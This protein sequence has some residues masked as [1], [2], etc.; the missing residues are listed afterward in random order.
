MT[1]IF[2]FGDIEL[3]DAWDDTPTI[4]PLQVARRLHT[5]RHQVD[6]LAGVVRTPPWHEIGDVE[7][8]RLTDFAVV[9][10]D[11]IS[12]REPD[13]PALLA[14]RIHEERSAEAWDDLAPDEQQIAIDLCDLLVEWLEREGPR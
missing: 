3:A 5:L 4:D 6:L 11:Y 9:I 2:E 8:G 14:R 10:V 1:D 13:N 7:R 12:I